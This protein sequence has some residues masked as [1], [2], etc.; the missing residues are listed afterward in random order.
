MPETSTSSQHLTPLCRVLRT[1]YTLRTT[2]YY[3]RS[4]RTQITHGIWHLQNSKI[5]KGHA[6]DSSLAPLTPVPPLPNLLASIRLALRLSVVSTPVTTTAERSSS[7]PGNRNPILIFQS[8]RT[9]PYGSFVTYSTTRH[10][11]VFPPPL[12]MQDI[13]TYSV[14]RIKEKDRFLPGGQELSVNVRC[15]AGG[16]CLGHLLG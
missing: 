7:V 16:G 11:E 4:I 10:T 6:T 3:K 2:H 15:F 13:H 8:R 12:Q 1:H 5:K 9:H 14:L